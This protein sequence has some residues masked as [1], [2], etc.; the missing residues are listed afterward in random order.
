MERKGSV[1]RGL[2]SILFLCMAVFGGYILFFEYTKPHMTA[3]ITSTGRITSTSRRVRTGGSS[4]IRTTYHI[5]AEVAY[6][7]D[8]TAKEAAVSVSFP[9]RWFPP[10]RGDTVEIGRGVLGGMT[11]YPDGQARTVGWLL[12]VLGAA[13]L[14]AMLF[15]FR[16]GRAKEWEDARTWQEA[17]MPGMAQD[18]E[19]TGA[20]GRTALQPDGTYRWTCEMD[21]AYQQEVY[22]KLKA[23]FAAIALIMLGFGVILC[24]GEN[25]WEAFWVVA[26]TVAAYLGIAWV[27]L[28]VV[29]KLPGSRTESYEIREDGF[30]KGGGKSSAYLAW[31]SLTRV[32]WEERYFELKGRIQTIRAYVPEGEMETVR[33]LISPRIPPM[34]EITGSAAGSDRR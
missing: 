26:L 19:G 8:G 31:D 2:L 10:E 22:R 4:R 33:G 30:R 11:Q 6:E 14:A 13:A 15:I 24:A 28:R 18:Q 32:T 27:V 20:A 29:P 17:E 5:E 1:W 34:A 7:E 16:S 23:V 3:V 21:E 12:A 9:K 25:S